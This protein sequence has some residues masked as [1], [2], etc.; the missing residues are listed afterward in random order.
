VVA[1]CML[2]LPPGRLQGH[3]LVPGSILPEGANGGERLLQPGGGGQRTRI[4]VRYSSPLRLYPHTS[5]GRPIT[6]YGE[7]ELSLW[8]ALVLWGFTGERA[9][10]ILFRVEAGSW[11][12]LG[13]DWRVIQ[14]M[15]RSRRANTG[16]R[17]PCQGVGSQAGALTSEAITH[18]SGTQKG[19]QSLPLLGLTSSGGSNRRPDFAN[20]DRGLGTMPSPFGAHAYERVPDAEAGFSTD[21]PVWTAKETP[22]QRRG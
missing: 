21:A 9:S 4:R 13:V 1:P 17:D 15:S 3:I 16:A 2:S 19:S 11:S 10:D 14:R 18:P 7:G 8:T 20:P 22:R 6:Y 5:P 12:G